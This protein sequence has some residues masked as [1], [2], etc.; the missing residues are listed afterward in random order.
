MQRACQLH[1]P[2][3][4]PGDCDLIA[5]IVQRDEQALAILYDRYR[6]LMYTIAFRIIN[7]HMMAEEITQDVFRSVWQAASSFQIDRN[8][9]AWLVAIARNGA[10]DVSRHRHTRARRGTVSLD[11]IASVPSPRDTASLA[12]QRL[13]RAA[14]RTALMAL[15]VSQRQVLEFAYFA[16]L[17]HREIAARQ[18][19]PI[20]TVKTQIRLGLGKLRRALDAADR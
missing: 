19:I 14:V 16:G 9:T 18:G 8:V 17:S 5:R 3:D 20:G 10:I 1:L 4:A 2:A 7:D 6:R 15:P 11:D 12:N 13:L